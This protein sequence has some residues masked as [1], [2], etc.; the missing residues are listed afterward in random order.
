MHTAKNARMTKFASTATRSPSPGPGTRRHRVQAPQPPQPNPTAPMVS[1]RVWNASSKNVQL[2]WSLLSE[3]ASKFS[4]LKKMARNIAN[5]ASFSRPSL[6]RAACTAQKSTSSLRVTLVPY[7]LNITA[8]PSA[9]NQSA[10][11]AKLGNWG[12]AVYM[13]THGSH[14]GQR[15]H[16]ADAVHGRVEMWRVAALQQCIPDGNFLCCANFQVNVA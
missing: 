15:A 16:G 2:A 13:R 14:A 12:V 1:C 10:L 11:T 7:V 8:T 4:A 9:G 3:S 5:G 6:P